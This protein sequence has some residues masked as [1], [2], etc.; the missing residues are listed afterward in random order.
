MSITTIVK[1][2]SN[3]FNNFFISDYIIDKDDVNIIFNSIQKYSIK[4]PMIKINIIELNMSEN[5]M[6]ED[7]KT[8]VSS[9]T[10]LNKNMLHVFE[11]GKWELF[12]KLEIENCQILILNEDNLNNNQLDNNQLDNNQLDNNQL[13][14]NQLDEWLENCITMKELYNVTDEGKICLTSG[15][16]PGIYKLIGQRKGDELIAIK[17]E[18]IKEHV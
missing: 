8:F 11:G 16:G 10:I 4:N 12:D 14:N 17:M 18:F 5:V 1:Q 7:K 15:F 13:D 2:F 6:K 9:F 3:D